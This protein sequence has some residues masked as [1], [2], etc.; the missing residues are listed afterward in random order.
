MDRI[1]LSFSTPKMHPKLCFKIQLNKYLL[2]LIKKAADFLIQMKI[3]G[4][5]FM[6]R[7]YDNLF[8][9]FQGSK[10]S[11]QLVQVSKATI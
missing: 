8:F 1:N 3:L 5:K 10:L 6:Q 4:E 9:N 2:S 7:C 11:F